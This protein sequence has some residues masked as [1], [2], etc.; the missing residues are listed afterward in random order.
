[1]KHGIYL[2]RGPVTVRPL[3]PEHAPFLL[4]WMTEP[5][6]LEFYEGRDAVFT[7]E[8]ILKDFYQEEWNARRCIVEYEEKPI[9]YLQIYR[10]DEELCR[11]YHL[12]LIHI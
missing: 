7:P 8:R 11:E 3:T 2:T 9:G 6:V 10:L 1:M 5:R 4:K 12:S